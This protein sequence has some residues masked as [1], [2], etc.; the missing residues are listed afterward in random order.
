[1]K[2]EVPG[3]AQDEQSTNFKYIASLIAIG[4]V[5]SINRVY[6][7]QAEDMGIFQTVS[8]L[9]SNGY[10]L[11]DEAYE[12]KDPLFFY[13]A[14]GFFSVFGPRGF[15]LIDIL[16][17]TL[18]SPIAYIF[19]I[20]YKFSKLVSYFSAIIFLVT[21]TGLY[22]QPFR[23][24]IAAIVLVLVMMIFAAERKWMLT[25][26]IAA[27]ILGFKMPFG[28]FLVLPLVVLVGL[29]RPLRHMT[30][31]ILGFTT[32]ILGLFAFMYARKEFF[33]YVEMI[34]ENFNYEDSYPKI[35]GRKGGILGHLEQWNSFNHMLITYLLLQAFLFFFIYRLKG[36]SNFFELV[37]LY[38]G[39]I[40]I[41]IYTSLTLNW[42]HHLQIFSLFALFTT[43]ILGTALQLELGRSPGAAKPKTKEREHFQSGI[44]IISLVFMIL[45][46]NI[47]TK[48]SLTP[49]MNLN[50]WFSPTWIKPTEIALLESI[51]VEP[52]VEKTFT[53]L[54]ANEDNGYGMFLDSSWR[55][56]CARTMI[57]GGETK[58]AAKKFIRCL[59][60]SPNFVIISPQFTQ[61]TY[62]PGIYQEIYS[63][64]MKI[65]KDKFLCTSDDWNTSYNVC[66][67]I[68][69]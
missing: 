2:K 10:R 62:F 32:T 40:L 66:R 28:I 53:R 19:G 3:T 55:F 26:V 6:F 69:R 15:F 27:I 33:P 24:Q 51:K 58:Y 64:S 39:N 21:L 65:L 36:N 22:Y 46:T 57:Y 61:Y 14:S 37:L 17:I 7:T 54:G 52:G 18:S 34:K 56:K 16:W 9:V 44:A 13:Y 31:F 68:I 30:K 59:D 25:G 60:S 35:L 43:L 63:S 5:V 42:I 48:I 50:Q 23:T 8:A 20:R 67:R 4:F 45:I 12:I 47:G 41:G 49:T 1:M 11:Y 38:L 29:Q